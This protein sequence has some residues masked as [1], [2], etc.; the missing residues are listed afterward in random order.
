MCLTVNGGRSCW[1]RK[2][3]LGNQG[4]VLKASQP[5]RDRGLETVSVPRKVTVDQKSQTKTT[6]EC[7]LRQIESKLHN[8]KAEASKKPAK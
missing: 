4:P 6:R 8:L 5:R 7:R 3:Q 1:S 2:F